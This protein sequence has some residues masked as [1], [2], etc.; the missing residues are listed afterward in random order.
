M[1]HFIKTKNEN[2]HWMK[3]LTQIIYL[4]FV[5]LT[6]LC[7]SGLMLSLVSKDNKHLEKTATS[8]SK[9][10]NDDGLCCMATVRQIL[11]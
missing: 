9:E 5:S 7:I 8:S 2:L 3:K 6:F 4:V 11:S 1:L 10:N